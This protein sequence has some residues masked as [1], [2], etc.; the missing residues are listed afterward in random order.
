LQYSTDS[1]FIVQPEILYSQKGFTFKAA[2]VDNTTA[3]DYVEVPILLKYNVRA[4]KGLNLQPTVAPS[5]V[6]PW[7]QKTYSK[8]LSLT[9]RPIY[10][11]IS[12]A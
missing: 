9:M 2:T 8:V 11:K 12:T 7:L 5:W 4:A 3:M 10:W 6:M 1:N